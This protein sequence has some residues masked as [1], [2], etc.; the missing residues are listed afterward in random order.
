MILTHFLALMFAGDAAQPGDVP[1]LRV[2]QGGAGGG[3]VVLKSPLSVL[4]WGIEWTLAEGETIA[5]AQWSVTPAEAGGLAVVA[6]SGVIDG[7]T[8]GCRV[9]GG[10]FRRVYALACAITTSAG[11]VLVESIVFRIGSIEVVQ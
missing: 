6:G 9:E 1:A 2:R 8:T 5:A 4:D 7:A 10:Q 3:G 11:R